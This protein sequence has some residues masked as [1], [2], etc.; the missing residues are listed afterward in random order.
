MIIIDG[1]GAIRY[2]NRQVS[3]LFGYSHDDLVGKTVEWL[4]PERFRARHVGHRKTYFENVRVR[5]WGPA[6]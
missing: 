2:A 5:P 4:M 1:S 6:R 3:V